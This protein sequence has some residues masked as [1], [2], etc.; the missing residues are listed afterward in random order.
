[1]K[2]ERKKKQS[3]DAVAPRFNAL[4]AVI[5]LL[6]LVSI[7]GIYFRFNVL[8][9]LTERDQQEYYV[10]FS[11]ENI[12]YTTPNYINIGD[13]IFLADDGKELGVLVAE[14]ED[15]ANIG[16]SITPASE[17]FMNE[18]GVMEE[19]FYPNSESRVDAKGRML[20]RGSYSE[21]GGL[22]IGGIHHVS[23]G[24]ELCVYTE[25][26]SVTITVLDVEAVQ[27]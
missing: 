7:V 24:Q 16:L 20:C 21:D 1:M 25:L 2:K 11:I 14:S 12:R 15:M 22:L 26:V 9:L 23:A 8:D 6:I 27:Q 3:E 10:S 17:L 5:I 18:N 19:V 4:D 13:S